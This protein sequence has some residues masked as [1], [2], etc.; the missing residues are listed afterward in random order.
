MTAQPRGLLY[1]TSDALSNTGTIDISGAMAV[2]YSVASPI[3]TLM[4]QLR[5]GYND[6]AWDGPLINSTAAANSIATGVGL[7]AASDYIAAT[8]TTS[9]NGR[10]IDATTVLLK[11]TYYGDTDLNGVVNFD[12][13]V[14]IDLAFNM[15]SGTLG[16]ALSFLDGSDP[17]TR[18][19]D[20]AALRTVQQHLAEFG[21]G[22]GQHF[23]AAVP[24]PHVL[25]LLSLPAVACF[26]RRRRGRGRVE[27]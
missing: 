11:Y 14:L 22:Y 23:V 19:M 10:P 5:Q 1:V 15:Q 20:T 17:G 8:G 27:R 24:E 16:R 9:F 4:Q 26:G 7:I 2:N 3:A 12:D 21:A 18:G 6:G 13:Y 25:A